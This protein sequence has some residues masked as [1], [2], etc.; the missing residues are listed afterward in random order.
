MCAI[1]IEISVLGGVHYQRFHY[2]MFYTCAYMQ[3]DTTE[4]MD[5]AT[6]TSVN[7]KSGE[8]L[9]K[10]RIEQSLEKPSEGASELLT[11]IIIAH[12]VVLRSL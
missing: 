1:I 8:A 6:D 12:S 7:Q 4:D 3:T 11:I 2:T 9:N 10:I 5:G